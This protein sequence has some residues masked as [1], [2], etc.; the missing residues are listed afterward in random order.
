MQ[1]LGDIAGLDWVRGGWKGIS[2]ECQLIDLVPSLSCVRDSLKLALP[3]Q[4][5]FWKFSCLLVTFA[6]LVFFNNHWGWAPV[7]DFFFGLK[8]NARVR[9]NSP[10]NLPTEPPSLP[11]SFI[12][13]YR[14]LLHSFA[15]AP[16][17]RPNGMKDVCQGSSVHSSGV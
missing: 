11:I 17:I 6:Y 5:Q 9:E 12:Q 14:F 1:N 7:T 8:E 16:I 2:C 10:T 13:Q 4:A 3:R 15:L